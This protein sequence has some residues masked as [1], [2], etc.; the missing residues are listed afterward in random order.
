MITEPPTEE[1]KAPK[2][3]RTQRVPW[4]RIRWMRAAKNAKCNATLALNEDGRPVKCQEPIV[5]GDLYIYSLGIIPASGFRFSARYHP[6]CFV[7]STLHHYLLVQDQ[8][9]RKR[10]RPKL[11]LDPIVKAQYKRSYNA[12]RSSIAR[13]TN[14]PTIYRLRTV[15][16]HLIALR[17]WAPQYSTPLN[18]MNK[19]ME[20]LP[21]SFLYAVQQRLEP[22]EDGTYDLTQVRDLVIELYSEVN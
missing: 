18:Q 5:A 1:P 17:D 8:P 4:Y 19:L 9:K 3:K 15:T 2:P 21:E 16:Q 14:Q 7:K 6:N 20:A 22:R 12:L 13:Y 10:G 11:E